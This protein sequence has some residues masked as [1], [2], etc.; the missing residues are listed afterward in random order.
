MEL[1][2]CSRLGLVGDL[3]LGS[4]LA[5]LSLL[6]PKDRLHPLH[7]LRRV[8]VGYANHPNFAAPNTVPTNV[9]FGQVTATQTQQ[10]ERRIS[11]GLKLTF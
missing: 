1:L 2:L 4:E 8:F 10:E 9:L 11:L 7:Q 3:D 6:L 5:P